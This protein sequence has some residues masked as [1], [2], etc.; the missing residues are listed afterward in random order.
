MS[1][2]FAAS[3]AFAAVTSFAFSAS[4]F[5]QIQYQSF[6]LVAKARVHSRVEGDPRER[7]ASQILT[8]GAPLPPDRFN[9]T[10]PEI[11]APSFP[12]DNPNPSLL[13]ASGTIF[14]LSLEMRPEFFDYDHAF[15]VD[16]L[17]H[18]NEQ[19]RAQAQFETTFAM[20]FTVGSAQEYQVALDLRTSARQR[21]PS[22]IG[23]AHAYDFR[24]FRGMLPLTLQSRSSSP[25]TVSNT[26]LLEPAFTYRME[27]DTLTLLNITGL[28]EGGAFVDAGLNGTLSLSITPVPEPVHACWIVVAGALLRRRVSR[29]ARSH[30]LADPRKRHTRRR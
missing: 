18:L 5:A 4:T 10:G 30:A 21:V 20:T 3:C 13:N 15:F 29:Y 1:F 12:A 26:F 19:A 25:F 2:R 27:M 22:P 14:P 28:G 8:F 16:V 9:F 17:N 6:S 23:E 24:L 11:S 7:T